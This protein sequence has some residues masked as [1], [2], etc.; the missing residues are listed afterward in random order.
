MDI[1][2]K[3]AVPFFLLIAVLSLSTYAQS[4]FKVPSQYPN[5]QAAI[6]AAWDG[7]TV[8]IADGEYSGEGNHDIRFFGKRITVRSENGPERCLIN[9]DDS[10][11]DHAGWPS[12]E[13]NGFYF[14]GLEDRS[15]ILEGVQIY[16]LYSSQTSSCMAINIKNSSPKIFNC[17]FNH[18]YIQ[19]WD[20]SPYII[21]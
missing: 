8:L 12:T 9:L 16:C 15:S 7:D 11:T 17:I 18:S 13:Y 4:V 5:I 3:K 2:F 20:T 1:V 19:G 21:N 6:D 10:D 14:T